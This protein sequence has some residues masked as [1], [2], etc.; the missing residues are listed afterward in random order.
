MTNNPT[1]DGVSRELLT[2]L[3]KIASRNVRSAWSGSICEEARDLLDAPVVERQPSAPFYISTEDWNLLVRGDIDTAP[4]RISRTR[5]GKFTESLFAHP[6]EVAALQSTVAQQ[7]KMIEH[8]RGGPTPLYTGVDMANAAR[9]ERRSLAEH[10]TEQMA[11]KQYPEDRADAECAAYNS[12][13][14]DVREML[15]SFKDE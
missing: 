13:L 1:I 3:V 14:D 6:P 5:R 9:D 15:R 11:L 2:D 12:A 10:L 4:V 7:A 8:L